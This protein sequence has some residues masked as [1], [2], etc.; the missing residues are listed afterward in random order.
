VFEES[1][2][3]RLMLA[4]LTLIG[5]LF[6]LETL[7]ELVY[8]TLFLIQNLVL[9]GFI[10]FSTSPSACFLF[11]KVLLNFLN[12]ALI[13]LNHFADISHILLQL[14]YLCIVL[15]DSIQKTLTSLRERKI[16]LICLEFKIILSL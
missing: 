12:V 3:H 1:R 9:L 4:Y 7:H 16:H 2:N 15:L 14:L 13:G 8:L 11:L 6:F 5:S 10:T